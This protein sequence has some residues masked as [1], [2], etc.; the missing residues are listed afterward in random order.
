MQEARYLINKY[1]Y[2]FPYI[3]QAMDRLESHARRTH[4]ALSPLDNR[5]SDLSSM[6]WD[7]GRQASHAL[8]IAKNLPF[9]GTGASTTKL[10]LCR[11]KRRIDKY[12][13]DAR[14]INVVH[15]EILVE[16]HVDCV[17]DVAKLVETEMVT[18]FNFYAPSVPM[19]A[20]AHIGDCW[21][22]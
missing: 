6:D 9:Q 15:D 1:F 14:L 22:H 19:E 10:A 17:E 7:D 4:I 8:N 3:K 11:V 13:Y 20:D 2:T 12:E 5:Q 18:A 21:I 16:A